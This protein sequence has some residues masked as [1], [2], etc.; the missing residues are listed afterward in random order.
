MVVAVVVTVV[1]D[2]VALV[3][4][5]V[6][7]VAAAVVAVVECAVIEGCAGLESSFISTGMPINPPIVRREA[8]PKQSL[9][10]IPPADA[11]PEAACSAE[12]ICESSSG[13]A[14]LAAVGEAWKV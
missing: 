13:S 4:E 1:E 10:A 3:M 11:P 12:R 7:D 14:A 6:E 9:R 2:A 8:S 5:D